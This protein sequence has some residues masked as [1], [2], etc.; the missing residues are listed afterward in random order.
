MYR[1][2]NRTRKSINYKTPNDV[3]FEQLTHKPHIDQSFT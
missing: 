1:L 3:F 2:N